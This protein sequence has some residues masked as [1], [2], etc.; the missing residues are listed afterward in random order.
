MAAAGDC[1]CCRLRLL[2]GIGAL[3]QSSGGCTPL[4]P[5][6]PLCTHPLHPQV[7]IEKRKEEAERVMMERERE[8][9]EQRAVAEALARE[10]EERRKQQER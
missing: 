8:A 2:P 9:E 10:Q 7:L 3:P 1:C 4:N 6:A 5:P